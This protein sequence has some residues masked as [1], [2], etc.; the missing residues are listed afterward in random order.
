MSKVIGEGTYGCVH[1]P[2]LQCKNKKI[3]KTKVSK[4]MTH[5]HANEELEEFDNISKVDKNNDFYL[6]IPDLCNPSTSKSNKKAINKCEDFNSKNIDDYSLLI[7][8]DGGLTLEAFSDKM[9]NENKTNLNVKKMEMFWIECHRLILGLKKL[10]E[11]DIIHHDLKPLNIVY[12]EDTNRLN[13][14]DFG[15]MTKMSSIKEQARQ[16]N[17][18][19]SVSHWYFPFEFMLINYNDYIR[20]A[21]KSKENRKDILKNIMKNKDH[22]ITTNMKIFYEE[23][24]NSKKFKLTNTRNFYETILN[25]N[26]EDY[27]KFLNKALDSFDVYGLGLSFMHVLEKTQ[28]LISKSLYDILNN[29]FSNMITASLD[30]RLLISDVLNE[31]EMILENEG[32]LRK[33]RKIFKDNKLDNREIPVVNL[34]NDF[35]KKIKNIN[36]SKNEKES[37]INKETPPSIKKVTRK[38]KKRKKQKNKTFK[39]IY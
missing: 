32:L 8:K 26:V 23:S 31:Y 25:I 27:N 3:D 39:S 18:P 4:L 33:Y 2:S 21:N 14:I 13:F 19:Y 15:F 29:L 36:I 7:M 34:I 22:K 28:H 37:I 35:V 20:V 6:G 12:N 38:N 24:N 10:N 17:Y 11:N 5:Y 16:S 30:K 9:K 1:K